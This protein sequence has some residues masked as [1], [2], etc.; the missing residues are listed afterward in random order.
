MENQYPLAIYGIGAHGG[1]SA[2][3]SEDVVA[4]LRRKAPRF[5]DGK[6]DCALQPW[7]LCV[8]RTGPPLDSHFQKAKKGKKIKR[9]FLKISLIL[10]L[11]NEHVEPGNVK[12]NQ[13][14][15]VPLMR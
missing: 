10:G 7:R 11:L 5:P 12:D 2:R 13:Y 6:L 14:F 4:M 15:R 9:Q 1:I 3:K 8:V